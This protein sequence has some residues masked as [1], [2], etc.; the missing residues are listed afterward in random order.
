MQASPDSSPAP[1]STE[2]AAAA[3]VPLRQA[4]GH[5]LLKNTLYLSIA[6]AVT[7]P[8]AVVSNALIG[9]YL[10]SEEFGYLYLASTLCSF[11]VLPLEWGQQGAL[12]ALVAR[13]R[14]K[15][16]TYLGTS[17]A[18]RGLM[19]VLISGALALICLALGYDTGVRWAVALSFALAILNSFAGAFKD[20]IR[21]FERTD[22]PAFSHVA[23]QVLAL[24]VTVPVLLLGG[25]LK[26]LL[27]AYLPVAFFTVLYLHRALRSMGTGA[28]SYTRAALNQLFSLGTPFVFFWLAMALQPQVNAMFLSKLVPAEVIGWYGVSQ[29]LIGLILFPASALI[30]ALYPTLCRLYTEDK[31]QFVGTSRNS[32]YGVSL[33]AI[34]AAVG[35]GLFPELGVAI[36][37]SE[38]FSGAADHLRLMSVFVF[39]V[40]FS[41]P[42]GT[43]ILA[44]NKQKAWALVQCV[45]IL[46]GVVGN[47][48]L[49]PY[50]QTTMKNG[51]IGTCITLVVAETVVVGC[52]IAL[53]PRGLFD[54]GFFKSMALSAVAGAAMVGV[55]LVTK[56]IS[57]FLA[58]P[59]SLLTYSVVAWFSGA[60]QP[61]TVAQIKG[62]LGRKFARFRG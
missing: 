51:A 11:A 35:T 26:G 45:C 49:I 37:G 36:F 5:S 61:S 42:L 29:R 23:Q 12:P 15:A 54:R 25:H 13:D 9:R 41:M 60:V 22:I 44:A 2:Q 53:S 28:L 62:F 33:L 24:L 18:W 19:G 21:G 17:L 1:L 27:T 7:I 30:G 55:A 20:T 32:L 34:P 39:L 6:Q 4:Q 3:D 57:M 40:Y 16:A 56:P 47:P 14:P 46:V 38:E 43:S 59:A 50:F 8:L 48:L 10:G 58:V 31:E 52:G